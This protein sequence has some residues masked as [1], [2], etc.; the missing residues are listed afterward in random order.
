MQ[1]REAFARSRI[2]ET[3]GRMRFRGEPKKSMILPRKRVA[4]FDYMSSNLEA[5]VNFRPKLALLE[6]PVKYGTCF[7]NGR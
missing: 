1:V 2:P 6:P 3:D 4:T 7:K 5:S